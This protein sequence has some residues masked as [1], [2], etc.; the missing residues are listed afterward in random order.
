[1]RNWLGT[2][3]FSYVGF[4]F[5]LLLIVPNLIWSKQKPEGYTAAGENKILHTLELCGQIAVTCVS[6]CFSDFNLRAFT[7]QSVFLVTAALC[8]QLYELWWVRYFKSNKT[9]SDF[10]GSFIGIPAPGAVLPVAAFFC[11]G[12]YG[13]NVWMLLA[14]LLLGVGHI[15]IH[16]QHLK[17][18]QIYENTKSEKQ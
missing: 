6:L 5:L 15:G 8:M 1:M 18:L 4:I 9:L 17:E 7:K 11:L 3:G 14:C 2:F 16:L 13:K 12:L 10:Y